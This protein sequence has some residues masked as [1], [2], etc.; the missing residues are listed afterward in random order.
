MVNQKRKSEPKDIIM[1]LWVNWFLT[2]RTIEI[3]FQGSNS[4]DWLSIGHHNGL[5]SSLKKRILVMQIGI[6]V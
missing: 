1:A 3:H 6:C 2:E 4:N 5:R